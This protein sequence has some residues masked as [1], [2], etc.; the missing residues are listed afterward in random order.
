[1]TNW[2]DLFAQMGSNKFNKSSV[3]MFLRETTNL[4]TKSLRDGI[5]RYKKNYYENKI[6]LINQ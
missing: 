6:K 5:K 1:M 4:D 3:L 2:D